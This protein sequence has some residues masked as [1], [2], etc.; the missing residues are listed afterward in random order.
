MTELVPPPT[1][2]AQ[3]EVECA[4]HIL[5]QASLSHSFPACKSDLEAGLAADNAVSPFKIANRL[6]LLAIDRNSHAQSP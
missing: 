4:A 5:I 1:A 3:L 6:P 2:A